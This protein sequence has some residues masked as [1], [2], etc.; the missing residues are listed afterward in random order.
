MNDST[1]LVLFSGGQDSTVC[2]A[3]AL[4]RFTRVETIGFDYGQRH[5]VEL[6]CRHTLRRAVSDQFPKWSLKLGEDHVLD[7]AVLGA[8]SD[9]ALTS[10]TAITFTKSGLPNTFVPG[11][12]LLFF[13][14]AAAV[15]YR[16]GLKHLVGGM[17]ETDYSGYPD[18][19]D[20]T[21]KALQVAINL[22]MDHRFVIHTP[23]MW[24]DKAATW[25]LTRELGGTA[26]EALII[27]HSHSCYLGDRR[28]RHPWGYG[29]ATCP[30]CEL[31]A[32]GF[33]A[34]RARG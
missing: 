15:A 5:R 13:Q 34:D 29:C 27:E 7:L 18:C 22:G 25:Q 33:E 14:F 23:L 11:R 3:W 28:K 10:D 24:R 9:T 21:L 2:L 31:R 8:I 20:D 6:E 1:A 32:K 4:E 17:C 30:A 12:N 26:L 16:R 19:R